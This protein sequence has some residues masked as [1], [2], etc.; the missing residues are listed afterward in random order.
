MITEA[1]KD[2]L[3]SALGCLVESAKAETMDGHKDCDCQ[4]CRDIESAEALLDEL[5]D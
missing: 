2:K 1:Q 5:D 3:V 4:L